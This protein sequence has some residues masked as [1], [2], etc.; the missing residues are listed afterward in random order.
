MS[1]RSAVAEFFNPNT[2]SAVTDKRNEVTNPL[3]AS[4]RFLVVLAFGAL[5]LVLPVG[6]EVLRVLGNVAIAYVIGESVT[7][8][9]T[10]F[11]NGWI[12]AQEIKADAAAPVVEKTA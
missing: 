4:K 7:K 6:A 8:T 10:V 9:T 11:V 2:E 12:K 3:F 1:L 5:A